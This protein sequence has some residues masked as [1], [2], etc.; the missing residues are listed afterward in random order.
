MTVSPTAAV[1]AS[2]LDPF[3]LVSVRMYSVDR[4]TVDSRTLTGTP[5][6]SQ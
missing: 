3:D 6:E 4:S 1:S 2:T 5:S